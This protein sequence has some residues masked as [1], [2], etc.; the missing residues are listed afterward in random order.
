MNEAGAIAI[1]CAVLG[2]ETETRHSYTIDEG[3]HY[4]RVDC[5][6]D[7]HVIE[8]GLDKRS[9]LDS[10][11][12]VSFAS[13]LSGKRDKVILVNTDAQQGPTEYRVEMAARRLE[14]EYEGLSLEY[15]RLGEWRHISERFAIAIYRVPQKNIPEPLL[16]GRP[17]SKG[18]KKWS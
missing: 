17:S 7:T 12:Q 2:G 15:L 4:I 8:V 14:V 13:W 1:I 6:T 5:E 3:T 9:S 10:V 16:T 18:R 11:Q